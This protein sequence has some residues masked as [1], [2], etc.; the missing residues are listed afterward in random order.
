MNVPNVERYF[1]YSA[2][3]FG[4]IA[5]GV[6][7]GMEGEP[8]SILIKGLNMPKASNEDCIAV[9]RSN[10]KVE[11]WQTGMK[12]FEAQAIQIERP[13]GRLIDADHLKKR[14]LLLEYDDLWDYTSQGT[15]DFIEY[16]NREPIVLEAEE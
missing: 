3:R 12:E 2:S 11:V 9:I 6:G 1:K 5:Q 16:I 8:M 4:S 15:I 13:H 10:G 14:A 7:Q